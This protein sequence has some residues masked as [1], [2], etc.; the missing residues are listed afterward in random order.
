MKQYMYIH[1][2][3]K[4]QGGLKYFEEKCGVPPR[5]FSVPLEE[6]VPHFGDH[7]SRFI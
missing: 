1:A 6:H 7:W 5:I 4:L 2:I 3:D